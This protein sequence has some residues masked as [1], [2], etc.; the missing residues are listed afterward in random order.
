MKV[1]HTTYTVQSYA[2][3]HAK[4]KLNLP[5]PH[6]SPV[7]IAAC[8]CRLCAVSVCGLRVW[9]A[10]LDWL[11]FRPHSWIFMSLLSKC[12]NV[13]VR[14]AERRQHELAQAVLCQAVFWTHGSLFFTRKLSYRK[15]DRAKRPMYGCPENFRESQSLTTLMATFLKIFNG[16]LFRL[17]L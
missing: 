16:L 15:D 5:R 17:S 3:T 7:A 10:A 2:F 13:D 4:C 14:N 12:P 8:S 6:T 9:P 1:K 11:G